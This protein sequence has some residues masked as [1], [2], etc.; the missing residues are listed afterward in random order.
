M[1][2]ISFNTDTR[3]LSPEVPVAFW[4][5]ASGICI[6]CYW[7]QIG[8]TSLIHV[9][10]HQVYPKLPLRGFFNKLS[11]LIWLHSLYSLARVTGVVRSQ[12]RFLH[13]YHYD[14]WGKNQSL[15]IIVYSRS[16]AGVFGCTLGKV[17]IKNPPPTYPLSSQTALVSG[18]RNTN[19]TNNIFLLKR[20]VSF[21][22]FI[23]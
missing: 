15:S 20:D 13:L 21:S 1:C 22:F 2:K 11:W 14:Q 16:L 23:V 3:L 9:T 17:R 19:K 6:K 7:H 5:S 4:S 10:L 12:F 18:M 8:C